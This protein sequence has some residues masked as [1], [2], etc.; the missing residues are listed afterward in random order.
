MPSQS[1][2]RSEP[3]REQF[4]ANLRRIRNRRGLSQEVLAALADVHRTEVSLLERGGR[5]PRLG[6]LVKLAASLEVDP[7]ELME[8]IEWQPAGWRPPE[9]PSSSSGRFRVAPEKD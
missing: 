1:E 3:V 9:R 7:R 4:A 8:G 2:N 6:I 5:E